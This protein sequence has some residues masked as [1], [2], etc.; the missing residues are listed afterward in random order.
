MTIDNKLIVLRDKYKYTQQQVATLIGVSKSTYCRYENGLSIPG[1]KEIEKILAL[2][3]ISYEQFKDIDLP[4]ECVITYP[5]KLLNNLDITI[6]KFGTPG[7][8]YKSNMDNYK[9]IN[10]AMA[11]ILS[12]R[13]E[14]LNFPPINVSDIDPGAKVKKVQLDIRGEML[15]ESGFKAQNEL[16]NAIQE[17][18]ERHIDNNVK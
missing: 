4:L 2:Y 3:N 14:A 8:D 7:S 1:D 5:E 15:I 11:A 12:I 6:K 13:D 17:Y 18:F 9:K 10:E 16:Y